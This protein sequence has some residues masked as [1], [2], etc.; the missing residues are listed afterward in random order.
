[1]TQLLL[2]LL[3]VYKFSS[4]PFGHRLHSFFVFFFSP[5]VEVCRG[6]V[7]PVHGRLS[8]FNLVVNQS[9]SHV[10]LFATPWTVALQASLYFTIPWSLH[11]L[12]SIESVMLYHCILCHP[13][14]FLASIFPS[15][16][17]NLCQK[18]LHNS[19]KL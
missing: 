6:L 11:K 2:F 3:E 8:L 7:I 9:L 14:L 15:I 13:L 4:D 18:G 12:R 19:M 10:Q 17:A 16:T 5:G 1:M